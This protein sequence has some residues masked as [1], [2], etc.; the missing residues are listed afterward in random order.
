MDKDK[1]HEPA[2]PGVHT[3]SDDLEEHASEK[4][5][6][7]IS[8]TT[9]ATTLEKVRTEG[10]AHQKQTS[11]KELFDVERAFN[12]ENVQ[13]GTIVTDKRQST[14]TL[15]KLMKSA[16]TEWW[17][18]TQK[19]VT[20]ATDKME[21]LKP[22]EIPT[23]T[24]PEERTSTLLQAALHARQA[25]RDDHKLVVE[26][27]RTFAHDT[28]V[29][30]G[31]PFSIKEAPEQ[32]VPRWKKEAQE[33]KAARENEQKQADEK[34][35]PLPTLDLRSSSIAPDV[36]HT[37]TPLAA[38]AS[39]TES[40]KTPIIESF[41]VRAPLEAHPQ[42]PKI[43]SG[44][45]GVWT[46]FSENENE[47]EKN[48]APINPT[49]PVIPHVEKTHVPSRLSEYGSASPTHS[50]KTSVTL[51]AE[52]QKLP[53]M[54]NLQKTNEGEK[55]KEKASLEKVEIP[56]TV[57][58][59]PVRIE[60]EF[61]PKETSAYT[62]IEATPLKKTSTVVKKY[63]GKPL[64][65]APLI[66]GTVVFASACGIFAA[67]FFE[68]PFKNS[69]EVLVVMPIPTFLNAD[70]QTSIPL[71]DSRTTFIAELNKSKNVAASGLVQLYPVLGDGTSVATTEDIMSILEPSAPGSFVRA[72]SPNSMFGFTEVNRAPEPFIILQSQNFDVVF[73]GMLEWEQYIS[74]DLEPLFGTQV[75]RTRLPSGQEQP[76][77]AHFVDALNSDRSIRILYDETGKERIVYAL[78]NKNLIIITTTIESL[79]Q[80][81]GRI[82]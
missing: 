44:K 50:I 76:T 53:Q 63:S 31:Q 6:G 21:F 46:F 60:S 32:D 23:I 78:V 48:P 41:T 75:I 11:G 27:I 18:N 81:I 71:P 72:L 38:Y 29:V 33:K 43:V 39:K 74:A 80:I 3:F 22:K 52:T 10:A 79:A 5:F 67:F 45:S 66:W 13:E 34:S 55:I 8:F 20:E 73:A 69:E 35:V 64:F 56:K 37:R 59:S 30:T 51:R 4:T 62:Y 16:F 2:L 7:G 82:R 26:K 65:T 47:N 49:I 77:S 54:P 28:E 36:T 1:V 17:G 15:G 25:P 42:S 57:S 61:T 24:A 19:T 40:V 68:S 9:P 14:H 58:L 12:N 70:S